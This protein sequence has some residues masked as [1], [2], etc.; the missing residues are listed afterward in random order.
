[1]NLRKEMSIDKLRDIY[2]ERTLKNW[3]A[4]RRPPASIRARLLYRAAQDSFKERLEWLPINQPDSLLKW[5]SPF[6]LWGI[7]QPFDNTGM[8]GSRMLV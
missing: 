1:M 5:A 6:S 4:A 7:I 2:L 8:A 3:V